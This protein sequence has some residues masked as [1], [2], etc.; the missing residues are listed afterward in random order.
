MCSFLISDSSSIVRS[1]SAWTLGRYLRWITHEGSRL[2]PDVLR[3]FLTAAIDPNKQVQEASCSAITGLVEECHE[4]LLPFLNDITQTF[5]AATTRY[6]EKNR[7]IL[8]DSIAS[9][10]ENF[11]QALIESDYTKTLVPDLMRR[12]FALPIT[13]KSQF[14]IM[15]C[16]NFVCRGLGPAFFPMVSSCVDRCLQ[17][18]E[19]APTVVLC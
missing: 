10:A 19:I 15:E 16:L 4:I 1:I 2:F 6:Q 18:I 7:V 8:Y 9:F 5:I 14:S 11:G 17:V 13:E 12:W 3:C